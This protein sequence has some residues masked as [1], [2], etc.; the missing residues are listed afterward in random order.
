VSVDPLS[1]FFYSFMIHCHPIY[2]ASLVF[3]RLFQTNFPLASRDV[4][5]CCMPAATTRTITSFFCSLST[6]AS[7]PMEELELSLTLS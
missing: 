1:I 6:P 5:H 4:V 2:S 3:L 7:L